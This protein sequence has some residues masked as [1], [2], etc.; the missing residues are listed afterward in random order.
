MVDTESLHPICKH[1]FHCHKYEEA[2]SLPKLESRTWP[3]MHK[4]QM[5]MHHCV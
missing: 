2:L 3:L 4:Y 1:I 5:Y